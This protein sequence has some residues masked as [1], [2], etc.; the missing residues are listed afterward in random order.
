MERSD[1]AFSSVVRGPERQALGTVMLLADFS[2]IASILMDPSGL[3]GTG[4]V[5]VG[6]RTGE[7]I[8]LVTS[9]RGPSPSGR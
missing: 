7:A 4:E 6:V 5:L 3:D 2:P 8:R 9:T 1:C